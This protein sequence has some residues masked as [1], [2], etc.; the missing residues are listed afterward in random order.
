MCFTTLLVQVNAPSLS[1]FTEQTHNMVLIFPDGISYSYVTAFSRK[2]NKFRNNKYFVKNMS[3]KI[4][5]LLQ[6]GFEP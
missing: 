2:I 6:K 5:M 4:K 3:T 1:M